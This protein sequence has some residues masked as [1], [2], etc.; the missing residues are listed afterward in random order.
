MLPF[1]NNTPTFQHGDL[2]PCNRASVISFA[3]VDMLTPMIGCVAVGKG[4][5]FDLAQDE[6]LVENN[7]GLNLG[8]IE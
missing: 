2:S 8:V 4:F 6:P 3:N 7:D 1:A 5:P